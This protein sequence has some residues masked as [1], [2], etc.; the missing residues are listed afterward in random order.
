M[1]EIAY[2][3]E[4]TL[5][6]AEFQD[7]LTRSTLAERRPTDPGTLADMLSAASQIVTAR[8]GGLLV[9]IARAISDSAYCTYLSDLAVD[10]SY[11]GKGIGRELVRRTH[12]AAGLQTRLILLSAPAAQTYYPHIG[13]EQHV[14]CWTIPPRDSQLA[15][16]VDDH[17]SSLGR[18]SVSTDAGG[19]FDE[20]AD[21][22]NATIHR[23]FPRYGEM[24]GTVVD[25]TPKEVQPERILELGAGT[26]NLSLRIRQQYP[27][28][29]LRL[30][31]LSQQSLD[32]CQAQLQF[33]QH[34]GKE[35]TDQPL[36]EVVYQCADMTQLEFS[37]GSFDLIYSS[38]AVHHLPA[39]K[40]AALFSQ[41]R[42]WLAPGGAMII[43][44]QCRGATEASY[45]HHIQRWKEL[46]FRAGTTRAEWDSWMVHQR[47][48]DHHETL[49]DLQAMAK[50]AGFTKFDVVWRY[51][52]WSVMVI[53]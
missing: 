7:V 22:Y 33:E 53:S 50:H 28:S 47:D 52:L 40:K 38:I 13:M 5:T 34:S 24:L 3:L 15:T 31:D 27:N 42:D 10:T 43:A 49:G 41:C 6:A 46:S 44:D 25:Y 9:G 26:G 36:G 37:P 12:E 32:V 39:G 30:V 18:S 21:C 17:R 16:T 11:Q 4:S 51:L 14:S 48:H 8:S 45:Q 20:I 19:F 29:Q 1:D 35:P 2:D 23:C